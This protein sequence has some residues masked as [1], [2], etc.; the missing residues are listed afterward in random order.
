MSDFRSSSDFPSGREKIQAEPQYDY[1]PRERPHHPEKFWRGVSIVLVFIV[2]ILAGG[3]GFLVGNVHSIITQSTPTPLATPTQTASQPTAIIKTTQV[4]PIPRT[5]N[6][7]MICQHCEELNVIAY[8]QSYTIN[9]GGTTSLTL[10]FIDQSSSAV[11][12]KVDTIRLL[13]AVQ[14]N[15]LVPVRNSDSYVPVAVGQTVPTTINFDLS[16][17]P[18]IKYTLSIVMEEAN[19]FTNFYESPPFSFG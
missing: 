6:L 9:Q 19:V 12:M 1:D 14:S 16:P 7:K 5:L 15:L 13:E 3:V 17:Q 2:V 18:G 8:I 10:I 11:D 4:T